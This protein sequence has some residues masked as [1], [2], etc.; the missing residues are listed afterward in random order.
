MTIAAGERSLSPNEILELTRVFEKHRPMLLARLRARIHQGSRAASGRKRSS[1]DLPHG[2][3][4]LGRTSDRGTCR[5]TLGCCGWPD[6][7]S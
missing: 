7:I 3:P 1:G 4:S 5:I 2:V 6:N